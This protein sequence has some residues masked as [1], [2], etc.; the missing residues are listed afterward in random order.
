MNKFRKFTSVLCSLTIAS[1]MVFSVPVY[2]G[3]ITAEDSVAADKTIETLS[4]EASDMYEGDYTAYS[5]PDFCDMMIRCLYVNG[6]ECYFDGQPGGDEYPFV[7]ENY[8]LYAVDCKVEEIESDDEYSGQLINVTIYFDKSGYN[9]ETDNSVSFVMEEWEP[10]EP[11]LIFYRARFEKMPDAPV[12]D[13]LAESMAGAKISFDFIDENGI[14]VYRTLTFGSNFRTINMEEGMTY[15]EYTFEGYPEG[16]YIANVINF[17]SNRFAV[18][19]S[20]TPNREDPYAG[21]IVGLLQAEADTPLLSLR[22]T[23]LP[24]QPCSD[25]ATV[26]DG[27]EISVDYYGAD[28]KKQLRT[29]VFNDSTKTSSSGEGAEYTFA[30]FDE[31]VY[32]AYIAPPSEYDPGDEEYYGDDEYY[33]DDEYYGDD[34]YDNDDNDDYD[35]EPYQSFMFTLRIVLTDS[36]GEHNVGEMTIDAYDAEYLKYILDGGNGDIDSNG[37]VDISDVTYIQMYL[38]KL[39]EIGNRDLA[40]A[41]VNKDGKVDISDVTLIQMHIAKILDINQ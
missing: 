8:T 4:V 6:E 34:D 14:I 22:F 23:K 31:G 19:L 24:S 27:A 5:L 9:W 20:W 13:N 17:G 37:K 26:M 7:G 28:G 15:T 35:D 38:A 16:E 18:W 41:D 10:G 11:G 30:G 25:Y 2:A 21:S 36:K 39:A 29:L 40:T 33:D 12:K 3:A 32:T 1:G